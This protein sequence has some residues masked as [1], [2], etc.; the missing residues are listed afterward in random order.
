MRSKRLRRTAFWLGGLITAWLLLGFFFSR[1]ITLPA[2]AA[3]PDIHTI[4]R[5]PAQKKELIAS[6]GTKITAWL[7]GN[8]TTD[9]VI[10]L[11]GIRTCSTSMTERAALYLE[12]GY[13][14]L[15]PDLRATGRSGGDAISFGWNERLDLLACYHWLK[16]NGYQNIAVHGCSLG[17]ATIIYSLDS[18]TDY[19]FM[20]VESPYDNI[21][22]AFAHRTFDSGFNRGLFWPAYFFVE[23]K[24]G[25]HADD[26]YPVKRVSRYKGPLLYLAGDNEKQI[27]VSEAREIFSRFGS[28]A[29]SLHFFAG[30]TH[31]DFLQ[32]ARNEYTQQLNDFLQTHP[33]T[34]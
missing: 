11:S 32:Y 17:A 3:Y 4:G 19:R 18:V 24:T 16:N 33:P 28:S 2:H 21:D 5:F 31:C 25:I 8:N 12:K 9:A 29:K 22:H 30:A 7:A 6:D 20:V 27:P 10:I 34:P 1:L 13:T 14:V 15:L 23:L 26:L